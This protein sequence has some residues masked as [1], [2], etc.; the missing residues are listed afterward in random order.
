MSAG[1]LDLDAAAN[2]I[3]IAP[4]ELQKLAADGVVPRQGGK[5]HPVQLVR[6][7]IDHIKAENE[8]S[9][10]VTQVE[11][12]RRL[13]MSERNFRDV[14]NNLG[15]DH[16]TTPI[17]QIL[18]A[19]IRDMRE[20]AAG[21]GGDAQQSLTAAR[22]DEAAISAALKRLDYNEKIGQLVPA[23]DAAL[24]ITD[25]CSTANREYRSGLGKLVGEI[26]S[27]FKIEIPAEMVENIAG[28]TTK[29]IQDHARRLGRDL[30]EGGDDVHASEVGTDGGVD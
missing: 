24:V 13:D 16:K 7:Y 25:W 11:G 30:V 27:A 2:F 1:L 21:R 29:R 9:Q 3:G 6:G 12:A 8:R 26:Q 19:Y 4:K 22:A 5:F 23:E 18:I 20:K 14:C 15:I 10:Y 28:P 17:D